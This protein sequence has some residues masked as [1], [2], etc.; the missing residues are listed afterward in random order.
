MNIKIE[1]NGKTKLLSKNIRTYE[2]IQSAAKLNFGDH[3]SQ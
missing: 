1:Y 3:L 2:D